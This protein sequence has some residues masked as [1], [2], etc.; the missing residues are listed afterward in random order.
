MG[1]LQK[2]FKETLNL[3]GEIGLSDD[4][5]MR[6]LRVAGERVGCGENGR[7]TSRRSFSRRWAVDSSSARRSEA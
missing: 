5:Q 2:A 3:L 6:A 7:Y 1:Q 4:V